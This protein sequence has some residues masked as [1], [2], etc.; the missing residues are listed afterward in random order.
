MDE[1]DDPCVDNGRLAYL[2]DPI[3]M[4]EY[5]KKKAEG[6]CGFIDEEIVIGGRNAI[7]GCNYGH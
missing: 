3:S 6:C 2:D 7:I 5:E 1:A 4:K